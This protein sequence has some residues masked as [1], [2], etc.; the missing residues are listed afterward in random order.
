MYILEYDGVPSGCIAI[1]CRG[2]KTAQ[3]RFFFVDAGL[4]GLGLGRR[5]ME[6]AV[7]FC[8]NKNIKMSFYGLSVSL[9]RR[10]TYTPSMGL[11]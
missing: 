6:M 1:T 10:D 3:L 8:K 2:D 11:R 4:R 7:N 9:K 5:L